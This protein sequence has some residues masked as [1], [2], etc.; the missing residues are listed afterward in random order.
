MMNSLWNRLN[1]GVPV[2]G[3]RRH[4][5]QAARPR[6]RVHDAADLAEMRRAEM[7]LHVARAEKQQRLGH[8]V[9]EHVQRRA[10]RAQFAAKAQS[11]PP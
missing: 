6:Q 3:E 8:A 11:P 10:Q 7:L 5:K 2:T 1:G 4:Q 9:K